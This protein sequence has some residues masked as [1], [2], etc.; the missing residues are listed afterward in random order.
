MIQKN[1]KPKRLSENC[2]FWGFDDNKIDFTI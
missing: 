1:V 2:L